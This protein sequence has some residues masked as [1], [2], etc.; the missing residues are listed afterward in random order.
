MA[1]KV[2][3]VIRKVPVMEVAVYTRKIKDSV[4]PFSMA[5][6]KNTIVAVAADMR[7]TAA[8]RYPTMINSPMMSP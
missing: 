1:A 7:F 8:D 5:Y 3:A 2:P 6:S 4:R